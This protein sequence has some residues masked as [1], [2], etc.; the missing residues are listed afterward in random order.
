MTSASLLVASLAL[1]LG[2]P[3]SFLMHLPCPGSPPH[4]SMNYSPPKRRAGGPPRFSQ[5]ALAGT[6]AWMENSLGNR[7]C[8]ISS[9]QPGGYGA[10]AGKA[11][12]PLLR[13]SS[14]S[15]PPAEPEVVQ[16]PAIG[17][18]LTPAGGQFTQPVYLSHCQDS[19]AATMGCL[20]PVCIP[21]SGSLAHSTL[22]GAWVLP[23]TAAV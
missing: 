18:F 10:G 16:R 23:L 9:L 22:C 15:C 3:V 1:G 11:A 20:Q 12:G 19:Q 5:V 13:P 7:G 6:L 14:S 17:S 2:L 21:P 4:L 8:V